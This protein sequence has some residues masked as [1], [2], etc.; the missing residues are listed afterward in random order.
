MNSEFSLP[1]AISQL[2]W[3]QLKGLSCHRNPN[4]SLYPDQN[5]RP[6]PLAGNDFRIVSLAQLFDFVD[7]YVQSPEKSEAQR[8]NA[9]QVQFNIET[10]R[11]PSNPAAIGDDFDGV[12]PGAFEKA[13]LRL[14]EARE[15]VDRVIVQSFDHRSLWAV[16]R[17]NPN[18]RL[19]ALTD[20]G[21]PDP[22]SYADQGAAIWSPRASTLTPALIQAAHEAGLA[23]IPWTVNKPDD[24]QRLI[25][26]EVDGLITDRPDLL[27]ALLVQDAG[28][29]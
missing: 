2:T 19:A 23:V 24:M 29:Q 26:L 27:L 28:N 17:L 11:D 20:R 25:D 4:S 15:L 16:R 5:D 1:R 21:R 12:N 18:I 3:A 9:R 22:R 14:V 13:V 10:K 6:T 7:R 8:D